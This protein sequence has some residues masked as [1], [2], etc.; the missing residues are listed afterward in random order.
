MPKSK[1]SKEPPKVKEEETVIECEETT[2]ENPQV[3]EA[4]PSIETPP[5]ITEAPIEVHLAGIVIQRFNFKL[6]VLLSK[7]Y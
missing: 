5:I 3:I 6:F 1:A 2:P 7:I 4:T